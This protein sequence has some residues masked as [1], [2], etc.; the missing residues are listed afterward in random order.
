MHCCP[1]LVGFVAL[2]LLKY[3]S[4][5][6]YEFEQSMVRILGFVTVG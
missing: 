4:L 3:C 6:V 2:Y 5:E 1:L